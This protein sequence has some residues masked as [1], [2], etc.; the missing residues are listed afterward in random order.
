MTVSP[1]PAASSSPAPGA[2]P[3]P[4][5]APEITGAATYREGTSV[6]FDVQYE[7]PGND[8]RGFGFMGLNGSRWMEAT[9]PFSSPGEG[10]AGPYDIAYPV[11]LECGTAS[12]H[13]AEVEAWIYDTVG[14]S[15]QPVVIRLA[16]PS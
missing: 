16:C 13:V 12:Q 1:S 3:S 2:S 6:Y 14:Q 15:S 10:I 5:P 8:A 7:D 9:Y 11:D 4:T